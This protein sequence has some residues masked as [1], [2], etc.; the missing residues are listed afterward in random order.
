MIRKFFIAAIALVASLTAGAQNV[1]LETLDAEVAAV[2]AK[3]PVAVSEGL[4]FD[5]IALTDKALEIHSTMDIPAAQFDQVRGT[6][7][8]MRPTLLMG[9]AGDD[10][11]KKVF[12]QLPALGLGFNFYIH[13][14]G[15]ASKMVKLEFT[16]QELADA[17]K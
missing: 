8:M 10:D 5:N 2:A 16:A 13:S 1:D 17:L 7:D 4:V 11:T 9:L 6:F 3:C 15:D 12:S 14:K